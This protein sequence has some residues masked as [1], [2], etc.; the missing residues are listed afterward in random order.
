VFVSALREWMASSGKRDAVKVGWL[1]KCKTA[2]LMVS[3]TGL[4]AT[5][6]VGQSSVVFCC[7]LAL[8]HI[9]TALAVVSGAQYLSSA[10]PALSAGWASSGTG[11]NGPQEQQQVEQEAR[12][13][14]TPDFDI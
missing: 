7:C 8:L 11:G 9:S 1:G 13:A 5:C 12:P 14:A 2:G 3:L 4:L 6:R 10:W